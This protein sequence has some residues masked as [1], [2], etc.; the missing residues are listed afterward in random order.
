MALDPVELTC[1]QRE[2]ALSK[3][4]PKIILD[5]EA[6]EKNKQGKGRE[7]KMDCAILLLSNNSD[8]IAKP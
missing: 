7:N 4:V 3:R 1:K 5:R 8:W 6:Q 2:Q